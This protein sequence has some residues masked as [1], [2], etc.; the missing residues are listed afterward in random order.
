MDFLR[1]LIGLVLIFLFLSVAA[2][3]A[4]YCLFGAVTQTEPGGTLVCES[5]EVIL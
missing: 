3:I 5:R 2:L 4:W 1:H